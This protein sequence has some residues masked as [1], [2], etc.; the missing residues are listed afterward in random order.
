MT[1]TPHADVWPVR[2]ERLQIR[3]MTAPDIDAMWEWRQLPD[4]NRWL[5]LAPDTI[6]A[7]RE[8]YLDPERL[9]AMYLVELLPHGGEPAAPIGDLMIRIG[10]AWA[11]LEV[12]DQAKGVEAELGWVLDPGYTGRGY[13]TEAIRAVI[14]VCFGALGL[15]RVHAGCFADNEPSWRLMERLGMRREELSRKTALHRSGQWLDGMNYG[16]LA[17]EWAVTDS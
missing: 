13:A 2:T 5:G 4:V 7:F 14:D 10:D 15:R 6:E 1:P 11:Q 16:I 9:A 8:R 17:E 12:T 3:P